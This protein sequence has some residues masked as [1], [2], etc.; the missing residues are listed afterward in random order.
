MKGLAFIGA[1]DTL[2]NNG[3]ID[4]VDSIYGVSAGCIF[5]LCIV[6][7]L[8]PEIMLNIIKS[9]FPFKKGDLSIANFMLHMGVDKGTSCRE[10]IQEVLKAGGYGIDAY[11]SDI[12]VNRIKLYACVTNLSTYKKELFGPLSNVKVVDAVMASCAIPL[13]FAPVFIHNE[14]YID[15]SALWKSFPKEL[16][17]DPD[18]IGVCI[19]NEESKAEPINLNNYLMRLTTLFSMYFSSVECSENTDKRVVYLKSVN[20]DCIIHD[21]CSDKFL[22]E[23]VTVGKTCTEDFFVGG[24]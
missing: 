12:S 13:Y 17:Q 4:K 15:G 7:G 20:T 10:F 1:Y 24:E 21:D 23:I 11:M 3:T 16:L 22:D 6:M 18:D 8:T 2:H 19:L 5:G 14:C 9:H